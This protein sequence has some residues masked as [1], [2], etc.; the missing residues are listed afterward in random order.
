L[1]I[2]H[3]DVS[4]TAKILFECHRTD[5]TGETQIKIQSGSA[6]FFETASCQ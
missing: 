2:N 1:E 4:K 6:A 5:V 3:S